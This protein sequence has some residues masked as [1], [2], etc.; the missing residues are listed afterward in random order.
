MPSSSATASFFTSK[1][2]EKE[3]VPKDVFSKV[4]ERRQSIEKSRASERNHD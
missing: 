2:Y 1:N 4:E 3:I